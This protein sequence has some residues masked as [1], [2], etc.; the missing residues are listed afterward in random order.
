MCATN[1]LGTS[2]HASP[3]YSTLGLSTGFKYAHVP[4]S[5]PLNRARETVSD[6]HTRLGR[7]LPRQSLEDINF[8]A[9]LAHAH[10]DDHNA[11]QHVDVLL[12]KHAR[13]VELDAYH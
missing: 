5:A 6:V 13:A 7:A 2:L 12:L 3:D 1:Q 9:R 10:L 11:W 8:A 4:S